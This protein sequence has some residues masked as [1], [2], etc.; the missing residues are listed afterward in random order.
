MPVD[1]LGSIGN[2]DL[3]ARQSQSNLHKQ[4]AT[5][6]SQNSMKEPAMSKRNN[7]RA[8]SASTKQM[9]GGSLS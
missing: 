5:I 6:T 4:T 1:L 2:G 3:S 7:S 8:V 9:A